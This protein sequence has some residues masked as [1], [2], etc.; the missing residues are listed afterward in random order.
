M[1]IS[2]QTIEIVKDVVRDVL[3]RMSFEAEVEH[4][5]RTEGSSEEVGR[6]LLVINIVFDQPNLLIGQQG[7][8]LNALQYIVRLLVRK[9]L[10]E[11]VSFVVDVNEYK[12][13]RVEYLK[14]MAQDIAKRVTVNNQFEVLRP[15]SSYERRIIHMELSQ[16]ESVVTESLGEEPNRRIVV[17]PRAEVAAREAVA[18]PEHNMTPVSL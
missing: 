9:K 17:R 15:M 18:E 16:H 3:V 8:N 12:T 6:E 11:P 2:D 13:K 7:M 14:S 5:L 4:D 10:E 1:P